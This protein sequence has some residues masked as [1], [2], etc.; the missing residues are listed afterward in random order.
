MKQL[1]LLH[2]A[3]G[4][5]DQ[6]EPLKEELQDL[7]SIHTLSFSGHGGEN[8]PDA[9]SISVFAEDVLRYV[10]ENKL[11][12]IDIFGYSMGGYVALYLAKHHPGRIGKVFTLATK[13]NWTPE[14]AEKETKMLDA[15]KIGEKVPAFAKALEQ[16]HAPNDWKN[17]LKKT[18]D[19]MTALGRQNS[20]TLADLAEISIPVVVSVGDND[21]MVTQEETAAMTRQLPSGKLH[22][23]PG[24]Q[25][26]IE[27][28]NLQELRK[29]IV[30]FF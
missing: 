8:M 14:I 6:L 29:E 24:M 1:L 23:F 26:P 21:N 19:M 27:K 4:A 12:K 17:L 5:K 18:A 13:F 10:E 25:H 3:I 30:S 11:E 7:F 15:E 28:A 16:R 2:G 20:L 22:I 9:F